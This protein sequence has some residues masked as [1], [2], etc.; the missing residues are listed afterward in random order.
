MPLTLACFAVEEEA[1]YFRRRIAGRTDV[2]V[3]IT[4]M[5]KRNAERA[6]RAA[7][8]NA[9]PTLVLTCG[10]AGGLKPGL[11]RGAVLFS[12]PDPG[13]ESDLRKAG[14]NPGRFHCTETVASSVRLKQELGESTGADAVEMESA[15]I[16][17]F[18]GEQ[19][20]PCAVVRVIL[21]Q[22]DEDLPLDF[23]KVMDAEDR[24]DNGKLAL[25]L[26]SA[27]W[28]VFALL[29]FQ[30]QARQAAKALADVLERFV[31]GRE[32]GTSILV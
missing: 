1:V 23:N 8:V 4:G 19:K 12:A 24:I 17:N 22:A 16:C 5:G 7:L 21:D 3:L 2:Q 9:R 30:R 15:V 27:P 29:R 13:L 31:N 6:F 32:K 28:K 14:A 11:A 20:I 18:C 10:F 25:A 26:V